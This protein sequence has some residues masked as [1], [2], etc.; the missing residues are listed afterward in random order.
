MRKFVA[1][2]VLLAT[3]ACLA[4]LLTLWLTEAQPALARRPTCRPGEG[5]IRSITGADPAVGAAMIV[6]VPDGQLWRFISMNVSLATS[7]T[8]SARNAHFFFDDGTNIYLRCAN[9]QGQAIS[10]TQIYSLGDSVFMGFAN[11]DI[12]SIPC[13]SVLLPPGHRIREGTNN[14]DGGDNWSAPQLLV[15]VCSA[16]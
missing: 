13:P 5:R 16:R 8:G 15:E 7:G 9:D 2:L 10:L 14:F 1:A 4:A 3:T 12:Q 6:T 11:P